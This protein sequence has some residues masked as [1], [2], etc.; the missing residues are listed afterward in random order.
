[1]ADEKYSYTS[2]INIKA[3]QFTIN[4]GNVTRDD[5]SL[6]LSSNSRCTFKYEY[7]TEK[8]RDTSK[9][10]VVY[11][12]E[13]DEIS[14]RYRNNL[15]IIIGL[16]FYKYENEKYIDG[17]YQSVDIMPY[18]NKENKGGLKDEVID[19][20]E[21]YIKSL[22]VTFIF[23]SDIEDDSIKIKNFNVYNT[24]KV[25]SD[26]IVDTVQ[27][28]MNNNMFDLV[29]PLIDQLPSINDVPDGV[30]YRCAWIEGV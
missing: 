25:D 1:M 26:F 29:I 15:R 28:A 6:T 8:I 12:V 7:G 9:L 16:S 27:D 14:T 17:G 20:R 18:T 13:A 24:I 21:I 22:T 3:D 5:E 4:H 10:K 2:L 30:I 11:D 23:D 19:L